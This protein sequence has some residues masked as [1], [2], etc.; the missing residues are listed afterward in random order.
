MKTKNKIIA[1]LTDTEK[2]TEFAQ[3]GVVFLVIAANFVVLGAL[4]Y[5][6]ACFVLAAAMN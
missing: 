4:G 3:D 5:M 6:A 1:F 2:L